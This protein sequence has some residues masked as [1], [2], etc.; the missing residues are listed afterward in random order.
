MLAWR[1]IAAADVTAF[2]ASAQMQPPSLRCQAFDATCT[3]WFRVQTDALSFTLHACLFSA[4]TFHFMAVPPGMDS[5]C[6]GEPREPNRDMRA[7]RPTETAVLDCL[8]SVRLEVVSSSVSSVCC[9]STAEIENSTSCERILFRYQPCDHGAHF[10]NFQK[11]S[12]RN[13]GQHEVNVLLAHLL[14]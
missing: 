6:R 10:I 13:A 11:A 2:G 3:A 5:L 4:L 12:A 8:D 14:E 1:T 9:S 7:P